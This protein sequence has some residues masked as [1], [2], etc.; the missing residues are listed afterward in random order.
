MFYYKNCTEMFRDRDKTK[1]WGD[2]AGICPILPPIM[3]LPSLSQD[4]GSG[5][6]CLTKTA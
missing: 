4:F 2:S 3:E 1:F 5:I 6:E